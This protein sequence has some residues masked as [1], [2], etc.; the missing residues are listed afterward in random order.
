MTTP[1]PPAGAGAR[2]GIVWP[3]TSDRCMAGRDVYVVNAYAEEEK[4]EIQD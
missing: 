2:S 4:R 1:T 3:A